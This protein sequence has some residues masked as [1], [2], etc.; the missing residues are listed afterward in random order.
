M[1]AGAKFCIS[2]TPSISVVIRI[3]TRALT[4]RE[5]KQ[6]QQQQEQS[7]VFLST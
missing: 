1:Q 3:A 7:R 4:E 6:Q 2:S 5:K